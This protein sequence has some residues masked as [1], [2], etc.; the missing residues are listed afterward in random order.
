LYILFLAPRF[1]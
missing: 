1:I